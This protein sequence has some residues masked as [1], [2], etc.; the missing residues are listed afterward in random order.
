[1]YPR[2]KLTAFKPDRA[3]SAHVFSTDS[4]FVAR[5]A[6]C[7]NNP[8]NVLFDL[9]VSW[10]RHRDEVQHRSNGVNTEDHGSLLGLS[11]VRRR[12]V[13]KLGFVS[14]FVCGWVK[15]SRCRRGNSQDGV[16]P[17]ANG[18]RLHAPLNLTL[19]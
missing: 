2:R 18:G 19:L 17:S 14:V 16:L 9:S 6:Y 10:L 1:M 13:R 8:Y 15:L 12:R 3:Y 4:V 7:D 5:T 11:L